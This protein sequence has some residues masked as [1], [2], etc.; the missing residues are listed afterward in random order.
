M[1]DPGEASRDGLLPVE[2]RTYMTALAAGS[3]LTGGTGAAAATSSTGDGE[4]VSTGSDVTPTNTGYGEGGYGAGAY[5]GPT[6]PPP[7]RD[8]W[9]APTSIADD[10]LYR[11]VNGDQTFDIRDVQG[12]FEELDSDEVQNNAYAFDFD[13]D[14]RVSIFDVQAL[15]QDLGTINN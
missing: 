3:G 9:N 4:T 7:L 11:D 15:F 10:G 6:G 5:G 14:G 1:S 2:R 8:E 12:F 13:G